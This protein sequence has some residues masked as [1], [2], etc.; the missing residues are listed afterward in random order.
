[1]HYA[2]I[3]SITASQGFAWSFPYIR[4][5]QHSVNG[6]NVSGCLAGLEV[7]FGSE[8]YPKFAS[9]FTKSIPFPNV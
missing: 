9:H 1:M 2:S 8:G 3:F 4:I 5:G 6:R 7:E